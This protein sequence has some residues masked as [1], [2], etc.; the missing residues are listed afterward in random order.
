MSIEKIHLITQLNVLIFQ[1]YYQ[2]VPTCKKKHTTSQSK[3]KTKT[4]NKQTQK[5]KEKNPN[6]NQ[7]FSNDMINQK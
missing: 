5:L 2:H 3:K 7:E 1:D 4:N 6:S